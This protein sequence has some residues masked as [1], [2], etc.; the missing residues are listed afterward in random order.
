MSTPSTLTQIRTKVRRLTGRPSPQHISNDQ[1]DEYINTFYQYDLPEN[2]RIFSNRGLFRFITKPNVDRYLMKAENP[3]MPK[4]NELTAE[5]NGQ[6]VS[7]VD[8]YYNLGQQ[9]HIS[10]YRALYHQNREQ[11]LN[12]YPRLRDENTRVKGNGSNGAY[13]I[14]LGNTPIVPQTVTV[15]AV[16]A[17]GETQ[18]FFDRPQSPSLGSFGDE[19]GSINYLTGVV[20]ITFPTSIPQGNEI[21]VTSTPYVASRPQALLFFHNE[22]ILRPIPDRPYPVE[23]EAFITP[24][25]LLAVTDEPIL[26][27][28][29]QY[30]AYG[31][32]K[33]IFEDSQDMEGVDKIMAEFKRQEALVL[34]RHIVQQTNQR[35][36]TIYTEFT[37]FDYNNYGNRF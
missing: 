18:G 2:V 1:I 34:H 10:G 8:V 19:L 15:G 29:W 4:F 13:V 6:P 16:D 32:A 31:A 23:I 26:K 7:A 17:N 27:Q 33:K 21:T 9:C 36:A 37:N 20:T 11:F 5:L 35:S 3:A 30:I 12:L 14:R 25:A 22:I 28:W 24:S